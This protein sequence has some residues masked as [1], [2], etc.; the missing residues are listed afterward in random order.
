MKSGRGRE[1]KPAEKSH[2]K[3]TKVT[4]SEEWRRN[5]AM[6]FSNG[7][8]LGERVGPPLIIPR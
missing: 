7:T 4:K 5:S 2:T 8:S 1:K 3:V 6:D